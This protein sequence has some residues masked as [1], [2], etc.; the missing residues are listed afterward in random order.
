M[1][2]QSSMSDSTITLVGNLTREPEM[3]YTATGKSVTSFSVAVSRRY[4]VNGEWQEAVSFFNVTAWDTL[5][6]NVAASLTK[7]ARVVVYGRLEQKEYVDKS[8][9]KRMSVEIVADDVAPSLKWATATPVRNDKT[10]ADKTVAS[11]RVR[12][13]AETPF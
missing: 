10:V 3:R 5:G 13:D 1:E 11:A 2:R 8:G 12:D 7:G 6:V 4:Q 9:E